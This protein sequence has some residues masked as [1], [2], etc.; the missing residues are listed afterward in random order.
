MYGEDS[1]ARVI[2]QIEA[3]NFEHPQVNINQDNNIYIYLTNRCNLR[4]KH[5]Y[6]FSG[7]TEH[8]Y[9]ELKPLKWMNLL[10][11][12]RE[13]G[14]TGVTFTG[15]EILVYSGFE[16]IIKHANKIGLKV[17][18]LT[19]GI[20]WSLNKIR[21]LSSFIDEVQ[22]SIDGYDEES[23]YQVRKFYGFEKAVDCAKNF[24]GCG[25]RTSIAV[26]PLYSGIDN[27]IKNFEPFAKTI[28]KEYPNLFIKINLELLK[29]RE[30]NPSR[31][32]NKIYKA[33]LKLL[34]EKLYP[35]YYTENF[36][37]NFEN[38]EIRENCGFG[39]ISIA[40]DGKVFWCSRIHEL[41]SSVNIF[42]A[43]FEYIMQKSREIKEKTSVDNTI[44]C[45]DCEIRYICG[46][47]CR[48]EYKE[49][50]NADNHDGEWIYRCPGKDAVYDKMIASNEF[51][52]EY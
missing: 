6:M 51:F 44:G 32:E 21:E 12:F 28:L 23:Y 40:P 24:Y 50:I 20:L 8:E 49:I 11:R 7:D 10:K 15:G 43:E 16:E 34:T 48:L 3:K 30:V 52:F 36:V 42:D 9:Q 33:N 14:G 39:G 27:F 47:G 31:D 26:T 41:K 37:F 45:K 46:G 29:G 35:N 1:A 17:T 19:N 18:V 13:N 22:I 2:T 25:V 38:H 5:C 4:C